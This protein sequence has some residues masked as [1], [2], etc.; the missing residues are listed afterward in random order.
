MYNK[1]GEINIY[2]KIFK[3]KNWKNI[4][5]KNKNMR[6]IIKIKIIIIPTIIVIV[7]VKTYNKK[8]IFLLKKWSVSGSPQRAAWRGD[9]TK[10]LNYISQI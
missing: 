1:N 10:T 6:K 4:N 5:D 8:I 7:P 3:H 2:I 9:S